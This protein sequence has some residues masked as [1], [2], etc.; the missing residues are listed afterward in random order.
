LAARVAL[1]VAYRDDAIAAH[2]CVAHVARLIDLAHAE[3]R[4][5]IV[6][7]AGVDPNAAGGTVWTARFGRH[8]DQ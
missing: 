2:R 7:D 4:V 8:E 5:V 6:V 1:F 3:H